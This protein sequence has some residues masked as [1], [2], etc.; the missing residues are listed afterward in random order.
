[1]TTPPTAAQIDAFMTA[2]AW[3]S[4]IGNTPGVSDL[5]D[6]IATASQKDAVYWVVAY[7][8]NAS[9]K[10][11]EGLGMYTTGAIGATDGQL[12]AASPIGGPGFPLW[13]NPNAGGVS[14]N[15]PFGYINALIEVY[16][17][18]TLRGYLVPGI[19][20]PPSPVNSTVQAFVNNQANWPAPG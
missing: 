10:H 5:H 19:P 3:A 13:S 17:A 4:M 20:W 9:A 15:Y 1:M 2:D 16:G 8:D 12:E 6:F 14:Q 11:Y 18:V 7:T